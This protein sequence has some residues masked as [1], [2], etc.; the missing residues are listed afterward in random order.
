MFPSRA[1]LWMSFRRHG[2]A[3]HN[4]LETYRGSSFF[5]AFSDR[6]AHRA[7]CIIYDAFSV[8]EAV[9]PSRASGASSEVRIFHPPKDDTKI[10]RALLADGYAKPYGLFF[11][12]P[13]ISRLD[14]QAHKQEKK[15]ALSWCRVSGLFI[16]LRKPINLVRYTFLACS[17]TVRAV[18]RTP[19][20]PALPPRP[21]PPICASLTRT[22]VRCAAACVRPRTCMA[23]AKRKLL[24]SEYNY[25]P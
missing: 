5:G 25:N 19:L 13:T 12:A 24:R 17:G 2:M 4:V 1:W 21:T 23:T 14:L 16:P 11:F 10:N 18:R 22:R 7:Y 15:K 20:N 3:S 8:A 6:Q 9:L